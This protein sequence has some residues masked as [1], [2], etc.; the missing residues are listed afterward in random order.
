MKKVILLLAIIISILV[1]FG[2]SNTILVS[3]TI[4]ISDTITSNFEV[5]GDYWKGVYLEGEYNINENLSLIIS[6]LTGP[7]I[8]N[9]YDAAGFT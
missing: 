7:S 6:G 2:Q 4:V 5:I 3:D 8:V 9:F 1:S